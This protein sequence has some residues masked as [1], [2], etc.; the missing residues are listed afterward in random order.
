MH[1]K[2]KQVFWAWLQHQREHQGPKRVPQSHS[3]TD[4]YWRLFRVHSR[5]PDPAMSPSRVCPLP[6]QTLPDTELLPYVLFRLFLCICP[7][8]S[9]ELLL[10]CSFAGCNGNRARLQH[11]GSSSGTPSELRTGGH[12]RRNQQHRM[13]SSANISRISK[14]HTP[15]RK[16]ILKLVLAQSPMSQEWKPPPLPPIWQQQPGA[17]QISGRQA[18][19]GL[20]LKCYVHECMCTVNMSCSAVLTK[21]ILWCI[22]VCTGSVAVHRSAHP[23][24]PLFTSSLVHTFTSSH[25]RYMQEYTPQLLAAAA[26]PPKHTRAI[27]VAKHEQNNGCRDAHETPARAKH[28]REAEHTIALWRETQPAAPT[29]KGVQSRVVNSARQ[30]AAQRMAGGS[31]LGGAE[32]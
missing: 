23:E 30:T 19:Y 32:E 31:G 4:Q 10:S 29:N 3:I 11:S 7:F 1:T 22:G 25:I 2:Q 13:N 14:R 17:N 21:G 5:N 6:F 26:K 27:N 8:Y 9:Q 16:F 15:T 28:S 18:A 24:V 12:M 20:L